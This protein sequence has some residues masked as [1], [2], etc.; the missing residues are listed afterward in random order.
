MNPEIANA[1]AGFANATNT[2]F[3]VLIRTLDQHRMID[4]E[5]FCQTLLD[6]TKETKLGHQ[7]LPRYDLL[8]FSN[9]ATLLANPEP[10]PR[11]RPVVIQ[12]GRSD[13]EGT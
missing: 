6:I 10:E 7:S 3:D 2:L 12:G 1:I 4:K 8:Q 11:W 5:H 9:L 13:S